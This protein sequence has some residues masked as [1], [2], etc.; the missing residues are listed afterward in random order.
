M[1]NTSI[2]TIDQPT[3]GTTGPTVVATVALAII[4]T[5]PDE[6]PG[7]A[8]GD[9]Q[10]LPIVE[11]TVTDPSAVE[12]APVAEDI[13][14]ILARLDARNADIIRHSASVLTYE[15]KRPPTF[16]VGKE[17]RSARPM[18][19]GCGFGI[20]KETRI[21]DMA[22][23]QMHPNCAKVASG[24]LD[25]TKVSPRYL[26]AVVP[27]TQLRLKALPA[28]APVV[29]E[30]PSEVEANEPEV[31]VPQTETIED[32]TTDLVAEAVAQT[33]GRG[34]GKRRSRAS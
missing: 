34:K 17:S 22:A 21:I 10:S 29:A 2:A 16:R 8:V 3:E 15:R 23:G 12:P 5:I 32:S 4:T 7:E 20:R 6:L 28:P 13:A 9:F 26:A 30:V 19:V 24:L 31:E 14:T 33:E 27:L 1:E 18:C 25:S 11:G